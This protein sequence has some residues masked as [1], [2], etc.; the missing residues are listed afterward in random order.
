MTDIEKKI[1]NDKAEHYL[2][3]HNINV[4]DDWMPGP[5]NLPVVVVKNWN[6]VEEADDKVVK[7]HLFASS[8]L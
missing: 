7:V 3:S 8:I 5:R 4:W 2:R 1:F 6:D